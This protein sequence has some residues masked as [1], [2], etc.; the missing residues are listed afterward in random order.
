[1]KTIAHFEF[2]PRR[3]HIYWFFWALLLVG[4]ATLFFTLESYR[5]LEADVEQKTLDKSILEAALHKKR[6]EALAA[7]KK[8]D[9]TGPL[10]KTLAPLIYPWN[11]VLF[12]LESANGERVSVVKF[13]H[14]YNDRIVHLVVAGSTYESIQALTERLQSASG[15]SAP[16]RIQSISRTS[17]GLRASIAGR[18]TD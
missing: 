9:L 11:Q 10:S 6:A 16:W 8:P 15:N 13:E 1:M 2:V 3:K 5:K 12:E 18:Y 4:C 14:N 7:D 17:A